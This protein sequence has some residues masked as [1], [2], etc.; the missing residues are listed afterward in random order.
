MIALYHS[1]ATLLLHMSFVG[2]SACV[3]IE[4]S[5]FKLSQCCNRFRQQ[6]I[7]IIMG[8]TGLWVDSIYVILPPVK[9]H[10]FDSIFCKKITGSFYQ[11]LVVWDYERH[12]SFLP[13]IVYC[14]N[15]FFVLFL[16]SFFDSIFVLRKGKNENQLRIFFVKK[17]KSKNDFGCHIMD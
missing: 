15:Q 6:E 11:N 16:L 10:F 4:V 8:G 13:G 3:Y 9:L 12:S 14:F 17:K 7:W 1:F 5:G 2:C